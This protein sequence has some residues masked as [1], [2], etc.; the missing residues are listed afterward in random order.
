MSKAGVLYSSYVLAR[1]RRYKVLNK[2]EAC[3]CMAKQAKDFAN[4]LNKECFF[5]VEHS[6]CWFQENDYDNNKPYSTDDLYQIFNA[7]IPKITTE[8]EHN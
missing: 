8:N 1:N 5:Y 7:Q 2:A 6:K 4:W 3:E